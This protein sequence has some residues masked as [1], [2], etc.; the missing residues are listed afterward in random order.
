MNLLQRGERG[1]W[2][3]VASV[4]K[5]WNYNSERKQEKA[6]IKPQLKTCHKDELNHL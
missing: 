4:G 1:S 5:V 6:A 3:K 2:K